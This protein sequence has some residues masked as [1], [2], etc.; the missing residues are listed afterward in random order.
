[1]G[2]I[3]PLLVGGVMTH[4]V[5][6]LAHIINGSVNRWQAAMAGIAGIMAAV[7][8]V[9]IANRWDGHEAYWLAFTLGLAFIAL[10]L[11]LTAVIQILEARR[12][13]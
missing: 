2:I 9:T 3:W 7:V 1:M 12:D 4:T 10:L 8:T 11:I 13:E 5:L 6:F